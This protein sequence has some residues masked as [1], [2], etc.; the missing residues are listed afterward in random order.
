M[1]NT[2][3][4]K[5]A[6]SDFEKDFYKQMNN[7]VFGKTME[8]VQNRVD[9]KLMRT[10]DEKRIKSYIAKPSFLRSEIF[11]EDMIG[12]QNRKTKVKL[13]K[14]IWEGMSIL[15]LWKHLMYDFFFNHLKKEYGDRVNCYTL[16][17]IQ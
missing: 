15:D 13:N 6:K 4:R 5:N 1:K 9:I 3:L 11:H 17:R 10:A 14:A 16:I 12:V 8:N 7:A 2:E